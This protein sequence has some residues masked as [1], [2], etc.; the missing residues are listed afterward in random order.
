MG[1][2]SALFDRTSDY[3]AICV[4]AERTNKV[5]EVQLMGVLNTVV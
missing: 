1:M 4:W 3:T 2:L 5:A